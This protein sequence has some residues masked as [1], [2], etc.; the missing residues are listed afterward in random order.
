MKSDFAFGYHYLK[1][2]KKPKP[3]TTEAAAW[4]KSDGT[5][6]RQSLQSGD[7]CNF[8]WDFCTCR[9]VFWSSLFAQTAPAVSG[10]KK[11]L[12]YCFSSCLSDHCFVSWFSF[13]NRR[14]LTGLPVCVCCWPNKY[15]PSR[16]LVLVFTVLN[17]PVISSQYAYTVMSKALPQRIQTHRWITR[18]WLAAMGGSLLRLPKKW[19]RV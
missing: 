11:G 12:N 13:L 9:Q 14:V 6:L 2:K 1:K 7:F 5:L 3:N 15:Q 8:Q 10:L 19:G 18:D 4:K 17:A 16:W